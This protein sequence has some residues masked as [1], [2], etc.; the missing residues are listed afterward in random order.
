MYMMV[1]KVVILNKTNIF[2][3][4]LLEIACSG[5]YIRPRYKKPISLGLRQGLYLACFAKEATS[6][7]NVIYWYEAMLDMM[8]CREVDQTERMRT[9][10]WVFAVRMQHNQIFSRHGPPIV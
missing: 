1:A 9:L 7:L 5:S 4:F 6:S 8:L 2:D 3:F 10:D